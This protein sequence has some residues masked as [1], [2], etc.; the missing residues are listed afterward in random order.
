MAATTTEPVQVEVAGG[1]AKAATPQAHPL[2]FFSLFI[3][4]AGLAVAIAALASQLDSEVCGAAFSGAA[5]A[6]SMD[7]AGK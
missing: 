1:R 2:I 6:P 5:A 3:G 4:F 7:V